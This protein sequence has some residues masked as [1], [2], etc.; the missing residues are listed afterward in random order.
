MTV[1]EQEIS[2]QLLCYVNKRLGFKRLEDYSS[3]LLEWITKTIPPTR[4]E[5]SSSFFEGGVISF[6]QIPEVRD[7]KVTIPLEFKN[8]SNLTFLDN[9][10]RIAMREFPL[11]KI[12][13]TVRGEIDFE[14]LKQWAKKKSLNWFGETEEGSFSCVLDSGQVVR[15]TAYPRVGMLVV[16]GNFKKEGKSPSKVLSSI[17]HGERK[18]LPF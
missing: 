14:K 2:G 18:I 3:L 1:R 17:L 13:C 9:L 15:L 6:L 16:T 12:T 4:H 10:F 7:E 11:C 5:H 8:I